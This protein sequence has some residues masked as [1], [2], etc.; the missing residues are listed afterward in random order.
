VFNIVNPER[1]LRQAR[2]FFKAHPDFK[3]RFT[4]RI[5]DIQNDPFAPQFKMH[6]LK[7]KFAGCHAVMP[8]SH[9]SMA[10]RLS[11]APMGLKVKTY[12]QILKFNH[13]S[14]I[15]AFAGMTN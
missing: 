8:A 5:T 4:R 13:E 11:C 1:F 3:P 9:D 6:R 14:W 15:P 2:R 12:N 10:P 7:V